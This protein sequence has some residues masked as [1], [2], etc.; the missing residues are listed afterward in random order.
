MPDDPV[1]GNMREQGQCK[2]W[3]DA[4]DAPS[5]FAPIS[6]GMRQ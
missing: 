3:A 5:S 1:S 6:G 4:I 2:A